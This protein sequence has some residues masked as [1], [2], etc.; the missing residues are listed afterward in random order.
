MVTNDSG[1]LVMESFTI[2]EIPVFG[3]WA[4]AAVATAAAASVMKNAFLV[5]MIFWITVF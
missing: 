1:V 5:D 4:F 2:P 3:F